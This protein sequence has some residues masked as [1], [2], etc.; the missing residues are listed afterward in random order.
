[1]I[2]NRQVIYIYIKKKFDQVL[3]LSQ[4]HELLIATLLYIVYLFR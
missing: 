4:I 1:V 2:W 3:V